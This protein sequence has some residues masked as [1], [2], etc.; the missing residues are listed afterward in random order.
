LKCEAFGDARG[1]EGDDATEL[2]SARAKDFAYA[3]RAEPNEDLIS[4]QR[5]MEHGRLNFGGA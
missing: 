1:L 2:V 3:A 4:P 5:L